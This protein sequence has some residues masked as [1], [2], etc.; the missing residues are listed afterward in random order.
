MIYN[1]FGNTLDK[2]RNCNTLSFK[3]KNNGIIIP[4]LKKKINKS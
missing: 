3:K 2:H 4:Y 1:R